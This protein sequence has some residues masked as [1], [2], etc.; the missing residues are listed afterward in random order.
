MHITSPQNQLVKQIVALHSSKGRKEAGCFTVEGF[1]HCATFLQEKWHPQYVVATE[2]Q[3]EKHKVLLTPFEV[4]TVTQAVMK[5]ISS[6][7]T[8][9]GLLCIFSL[10]EQPSFDTLTSGPVL[11]NITD[12][13]NM[14]TLI[15]SAAAFGYKS[16]IIIDG[17]DP[18]SPKVIQ[19]VAGTLAKVSLFC[20]SWQALLKIKKVPLIGLV[21]SE[22]ITPDELQTPYGLF[23]IGNEAH[24][25]TQEQ[26]NDCDLLV[27]LPMH[28]QIESLNAAIAGSIMLYLQ[29]S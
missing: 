12:P 24:G 26:Q 20:I 4:T 6:A 9:S 18:F 28:G 2:E 19:S 25:L 27:T 7:K 5:K 8:P 1:R 13:G 21:V 14:G 23:A 29:Q 3:A 22:G 16:V 15:R 17:C 11:A 10:P